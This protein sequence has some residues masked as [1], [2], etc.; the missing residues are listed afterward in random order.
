MIFKKSLGVS[1]ALYL[2]A[3][4]AFAGN[5]SDDALLGAFDAYRAGDPIKFAKHAQ[6]LNHHVLEPWLEYWR[7]S[8]RLEDMPATEVRAFLTKFERTYVAELLREEWLKVLGKRGDWQ[9]FD[10]QAA[11]YSRDDL[12]VRCYGWASRLQRGDE[13]AYAEA[14]AMWLEPRELPEGCS[15]LA[16]AMMEEGQLTLSDV[17]RRVRVLFEYGQITAAKTALGYLAKNEAPDERMLAEAARQPKRLLSRLPKNLEHRATREV[18]VLAVVRFAR[19]DEDGAAAVSDD[20][21]DDDEDDAPSGK[22]PG[23]K[24]TDRKEVRDLLAMGRDKGFLTYD[25]VN[26]ALPADIVSSDQIDDVMSMFG[27]NDIA[28]VDEANKVKLPDT[29][30]SEFAPECENPVIALMRSQEGIQEM[31]GT[32]RLGAYPCKLRPG[33]RVAQVYGALEVSERHRHR[34]EVSN[35]YRD[36]LAEYGMRCAGLSPDGSLVEMI[37]LPDHPWFIGCQFHPEL[38]SRPTRPHPLFA[39]FVGAARQHARARGAAPVAQTE[40]SSQLAGRRD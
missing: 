11:F 39:G 29:N 22:K 10:R 4:P 1:V 23:G 24:A 37:E 27:D 6:K 38:K 36:V 34:Y 32:M 5:S 26:D 3:A 13:S 12:E 15:K 7:L 33:S 16:D 17:W 35:A 20:D 8:L 2:A 28:I 9:E 19:A 40:R 18:V 25:E 14:A 21:E 30:S 31:G